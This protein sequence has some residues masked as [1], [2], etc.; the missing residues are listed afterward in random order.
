[1][2]F[3]FA[4]SLSIIFLLLCVS[5]PVIAQSSKKRTSKT[6]NTAKKN[7]TKTK[8]NAKKNIAKTKPIARE[9]TSKT[10]LAKENNSQVKSDSKNLQWLSSACR[11]ERFFLE[12]NIEEANYTRQKAL[13]V[14]QRL[15]DS[16]DWANQLPCCP[17]TIDIAS[18]SP[19]FG[20]DNWIEETYEELREKTVLSCFHPNANSAIRTSR[21]YHTVSG[22]NSGQQCTYDKSGK[23]IPPNQPGAGT[24]DFVSPTVNGEEHEFFDVFSW[25]KLSLSEYNSVW[26]PNPGCGSPMTYDIDPTIINHV[27]MYVKRG[28]VINISARGKIK[29]DVEGNETGPEGSLVIP[30]TDVG[31]LGR[32]IAPNPFPTAKPGALLGGVYTGDLESPNQYITIDQENLFYAGKAGDYRMPATG[33][34]SF[35]VNDG[36]PQN[37]SGVF[38]VTVYRKLAR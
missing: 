14:R 32:L 9:V 3:Q 17:E 16:S 37:N 19:F 22:Q 28:D 7:T 35:A 24:P 30:K 2:K 11:V 29:F 18:E 21:L 1:M 27:W 31:I 13:T 8:S 15:I 38:N 25:T 12:D 4:L 6:K 33:Y 36:Y 34:L 5:T 26:K 23:L 20:F 10:N